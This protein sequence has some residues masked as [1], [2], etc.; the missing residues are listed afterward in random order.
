MIKTNPN[1]PPI[2]RANI[3]QPMIEQNKIND[4]NKLKIN[5]I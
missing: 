5:L 4:S 3:I 2:N 1:N